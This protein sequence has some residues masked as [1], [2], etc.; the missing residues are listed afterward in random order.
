M[1]NVY[2][3]LYFNGNCRE[4]MTFYQQ[5]LGGELE[6]DVIKDSPAAAQLPPE[7]QDQIMHAGLRNGNLVLMAS[8]MC[9]QGEVAMGGPVVLCYSASDE[10]DARRCFAKL[11]A[12]GKVTEPLGKQF[13]GLY[14]SLTDKYGLKWM[15][16]CDIQ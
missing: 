13:F 11:S 7:V 14:G 9:G 8:D 15:V 5:C 3:Y 16:H 2:A 1:S 10:E 4:A 6:L 12:G